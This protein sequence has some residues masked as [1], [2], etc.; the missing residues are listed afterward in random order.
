MT[1]TV[2]TPPS[3]AFSP[4]SYPGIRRYEGDGEVRRTNPAGSPEAI[5]IVR[6]FILQEEA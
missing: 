6:A 3:R 1:T 4:P 2:G 5:R